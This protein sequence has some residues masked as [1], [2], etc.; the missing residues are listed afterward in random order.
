MNVM[1][2]INVF[3]SNFSKCFFV[4]FLMFL[5][6]IADDCSFYRHSFF[7]VGVYKQVKILMLLNYVFINTTICIII[8]TG[9]ITAAANTATTT[10]AITATTGNNKN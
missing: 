3:S 5:W 8:A 10:Y 4:F 1:C 9:D 7:V 6:L 2:F